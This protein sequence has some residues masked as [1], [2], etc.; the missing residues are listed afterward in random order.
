MDGTGVAFAAAAL[1]IG[2]A[3]AWSL[4]PLTPAGRRARARARMREAEPRPATLPLRRGGPATATELN[5]LDEMNEAGAIDDAQAEEIEADLL[6][7]G[8]R[9]QGVSHRSSSG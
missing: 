4:A 3:L 2:V 8:P 6:G 7:P 5:A 9:R 1:V